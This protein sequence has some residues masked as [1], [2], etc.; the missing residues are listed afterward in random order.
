MKLEFRCATCATAIK[1]NSE[2]E[3]LAIKCKN[4]GESM[5]VPCFFASKLPS[6]ENELI[7][8]RPPFLAQLKLYLMTLLYLLSP[9]IIFNPRQLKSKL[10]QRYQSLLTAYICRT[11][12]LKKINRYALEA[13]EFVKTQTG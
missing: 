3:G 11:V 12:Y 10:S 5:L 1:S 6:K 4:C 13:G 8:P 2:L 7:A 9:Q